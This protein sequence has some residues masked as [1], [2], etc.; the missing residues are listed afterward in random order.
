[1]TRKDYNRFA[2]MLRNR[3]STL[4]YQKAATEDTKQH[5]AIEAR[6]DELNIIENEL[7]ELFWEDN[8][9]FNAKRFR[10]AARS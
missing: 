5:A 4:R 8:A 3:R 1:M 6:A 7:I 10:E 2:Q 9:N